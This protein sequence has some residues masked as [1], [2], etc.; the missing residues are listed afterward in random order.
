MRGALVVKG[1]KQFGFQK[2]N[3]ASY[4]I[5]SLTEN[6]QKSV[7][8][9]QIACGVFVGL[10]KVFDTIDYTVLLNKLS[11]YSIRGIAILQES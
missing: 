1:L 9:K 2:K 4:T 5:I 11:Y 8:D 7:D 3:S 6:I 10:E